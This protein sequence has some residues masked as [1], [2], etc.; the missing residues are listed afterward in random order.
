[1][2]EMSK[3]DDEWYRN[4]PKA[5]LSKRPMQARTIDMDMNGTFKKLEID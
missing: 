1:M 5:D 3:E 4:M 2:I